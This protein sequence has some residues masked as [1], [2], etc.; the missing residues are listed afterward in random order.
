MSKEEHW[1]HTLF[2]DH[3]EFFLPGMEAHKQIASKESSQL[4]KIIGKQFQQVPA[5]STKVL[6]LCCG[7]GIHAIALANEGYEVVGFDLSKHCLD[8]AEHL[9]KQNELSEKRVRFYQGDVRQVFDILSEK[10]E[11]GFN[12]I[13]SIGNSFGYYGE[14]EDLQVLKDLNDLASSNCILVLDVINREWLVRNCSPYGFSQISQTIQMDAARQLNLEISFVESEWK[15]YETR[16]MHNGNSRFIFSL[17]WQLR[18]YSFDELRGLLDKLGWGYLRSFGS[19]S[20]L[21]PLT[22]DSYHIVLISTKKQ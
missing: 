2:V 3:P 22:A 19:I 18:A 16:G 4:C 14:K 1:T 5:A 20:S 9:A 15:F 13:L 17:K 11:K 10:G 12:A 8:K 7:I 21:A 6:D